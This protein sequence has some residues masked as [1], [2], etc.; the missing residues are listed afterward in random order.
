[1]C[2]SNFEPIGIYIVEEERYVLMPLIEYSNKEDGIFY[3]PVTGLLVGARMDGNLLDRDS[4]RVLWK[5]L[6]FEECLIGL[7]TRKRG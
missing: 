7:E 1:M 2:Y 4:F 6:S 5:E 3:I